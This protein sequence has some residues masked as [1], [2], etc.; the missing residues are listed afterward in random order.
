MSKQKVAYNRKGLTR[1]SEEIESKIVA[2]I[3]GEPVEGKPSVDNPAD[4][5][6]LFAED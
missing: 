3:K 2:L 4:E 1:K 5:A 6:D